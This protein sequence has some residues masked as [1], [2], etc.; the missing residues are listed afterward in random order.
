[1]NQDNILKDFQKIL[2]SE[3]STEQT[4]QDYLEQHTALFHPPFE[5]NHSVHLSLL[6]SKF[7]LDTS[8][9]TDFVYLTKSSAFWWVVLVELEHPR[10]RLFNKSA[11]P[12]ADLTAAIG[13]VND[14]RNYIE[15]NP[16]AIEK[17]TAPLRKPLG[18]NKI[19]FKYALVIG[20][21][22]EIQADQR[23]L[24]AFEGLQRDDFRVLTYDSLVSAFQFRP[25]QVLDV[26]SQRGQKFSFKYK[27][28]ENTSLFS[29]LSPNEIE[30]SPDDVAHYKALGYDMDQWLAGESL[31]MN[32]KI[33]RAAG[34][35]KIRE[36]MNELR[37]RCQEP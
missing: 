2:D 24:D 7:K 17:K 16:S 30:L 26:M 29:W 34:F 32:G 27:H 3:D 25:K 5:L 28:L 37:K 31:G 13:Q 20:R 35:E 14:W 21:T 15:R 11:L 18:G 1:M 33:T 23:K 22:Q 4:F 9:T 36:T 8:L 6:L 10:K 19:K 12:S